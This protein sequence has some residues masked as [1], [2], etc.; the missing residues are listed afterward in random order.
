[1]KIVNQLTF[2]GEVISE[3]KVVVQ[4]LVSLSKKFQVKISSLEDLKDMSTMT[5]SELSNSLQ[6]VELRQAFRDK[7]IVYEG[8]FAANQTTKMHAGSS[9]NKQQFGK[10]GKEKKES[11]DRRQKGK[12]SKFPPCQHC[13]KT[14]HTER[15]YWYRPEMQCKGCKEFGHMEK[16]CKNKGKT[17][18]QQAQVAKKLQEK[19]EQ[20]EEQLFTTN[21]YRTQLYSQTWL[22]DNGCTK[23]MTSDESLFVNL[24]KS[25]ISKFKIRNGEYLQVK[26]VG[27]IFVNTSSGTKMINDVLFVLGITLNLLS[28]GQML[29]KNYFLKFDNKKC[30]VYDLDGVELMIVKM[31]HRSFCLE[32][33]E[34]NAQTFVSSDQESVKWHKRLGHFHGKGL[35]LLHEKELTVGVPKVAMIER[36]FQACQ[37]GKQTKLSFSK[38]ETLKAK[39]K[40]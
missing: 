34:L 7:V 9:S 5:I 32:L 22:L 1:M 2:L 10:K 4:V 20:P 15:Y 36:V 28:I 18:Q 40:L 35:K 21:C 27:T 17:N 38:N 12:K 23:H 8:A 26:G 33:S 19:E 37:L 30:F 14:S 13:K 31:M 24:K 6:A 29:E 39:E 3:N 16:V 11:F 25:K